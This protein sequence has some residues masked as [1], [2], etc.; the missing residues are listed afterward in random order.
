MSN[1]ESSQAAQVASNPSCLVLVPE[2]YGPQNVMLSAG[3]VEPAPSI[4][5]TRHFAKQLSTVSTYTPQPAA[6][7]TSR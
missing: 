7:A 4:L 5:E 1:P 2:T 3:D 6:G